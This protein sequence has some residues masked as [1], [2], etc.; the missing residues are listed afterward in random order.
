MALDQQTPQAL[1]RHGEQ[2]ACDHLR[3]LGYRILA[4]NLRVPP[5]EIDLVALERRTL[6]FVE[7]RTRSGSGFGTP[8]ESI[9]ARKRA[10]LLRAARAALARG[11][12]LRGLEADG[13]FID[14]GVPDSYAAAQESVAAWWKARVGGP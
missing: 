11:G 7:V 8:E 10:R 6:C 4:R 1:G 9:D 14:I 2:L 5:L 13:F 12:W 3:A